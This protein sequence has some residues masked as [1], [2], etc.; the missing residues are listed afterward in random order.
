MKKL[1]FLTLICSVLGIS[2]PG[3]RPEKPKNLKVLSD[4]LNIDQVR[5]LMFGYSGALGVR[6]EYCH[7]GDDTRRPP[8]M[9][10]ASDM[11][12]TKKA[13]REMITLTASINNRINDIFKKAEDAPTEVTCITCHRGVPKPERLEN[14]LWKDYQAGGLEKAKDHYMELRLQFYGSFAYD[15]REESLIR[16]AEK[17][18]EEKKLDDAISILTINAGYFPDSPRTM[19]ALASVF[20]QNQKADTAKSLLNKVLSIDP[21]NWQAKRLM[22]NLEMKK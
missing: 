21:N 8:Q 1:L 15:F 6:C 17:C 11:M 4:T 5:Q 19:T 16:V 20:L 2:Q 14:L 13:A 9:D 3:P 22:Q 12:T 18:A 10:F 7:V